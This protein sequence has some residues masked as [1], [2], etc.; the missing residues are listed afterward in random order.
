MSAWTRQPINGD[1]TYTNGDRNGSPYNRRHDLEA[2]SRDTSADERSRSRGPPGYGGF[3]RSAQD[4]HSP[5]R[6][7]RLDRSHAS[8][9]S[10]DDGRGWSSSRSRSRPA[11]AR[12]GDG[13]R[14][15]E[16]ILRYINQQW[17]FMS[18]DNCVPVKV[19]LQLMDSSSLGLA[20]Q[21]DQFRDT[22]Q[23][24]QDAL[25]N[26]VNEHHQGFNS[27]IGTFHQIQASIHASQARV[28]TLKQSLVQAKTN[29]RTTRPELK[30]FATS[31]QSYDQM[32][33]TLGFIEQLQVMPEK[34][35]ALIS[36]K[37]FL[38]AVDTL[39]DALRL[40]RKPEMEDIG[41]LTELRVYFHNQ[42]HSVTDILIEELHSHLYLK[43]PYCEERWKQYATRTGGLGAATFDME[44]RQL[45]RFLDSLDSSQPLVEDTSRNPEADTFTYIQL[46]VESL[47][48]MSCLDIAVNAIDQRL[49]VELFRVVEQSYTEVESR[50]PSAMRNATKKPNEKLDIFSDSD[51]DKKTILEDT[52]STLYA[53]FEAIAEGHRV[54]HESVSTLFRRQGGEDKALLRSFNELWKLYQ[55]EIR[56]LLHDHLATDGSLGE[57]TRKDNIA[58]AN[59]FRP[60]NRDRNKRLFKLSDTDS[61]S[62]ELS[63]EREDLDFIL[64]SSVPGLASTGA[65]QSITKVTESEKESDRSATGHKLLVEP[66]VFN[67][68]ILLP[69]SISFLTRLRDVVPPDEELSKRSLTSF[70]DDFLIN[71]FYPQLEYTLTDLC[72]AAAA[73]TD[74]WLEDPKWQA[75]AQV[76]I[77]KGTAQFFDLIEAFC[78]MLDSLPHDQT[79]S[80]LVISQMRDYYNKCYG[81]FKALVAKPQLH[82][83]EERRPKKSAALAEYN[84]DM[85]DLVTRLLSS[86]QED[87]DVDPLIQQETTTLISTA[88]SQ[89]LLDADLILDHKTL[90]SL[91]TLYTSIRWFSTRVSGLRHISQTA[92][93]PATSSSRNPTRRWTTSPRN[94]LQP[95]YLPLDHESARDFDNLHHSFTDLSALV[96]RTLHL[97]L[98]LQ[99]LA[100]VTRAL[101]TT[102]ILKQPYNDPDPA[103]LTLGSGLLVLDSNLS[104][105]LPPTQYTTV[106]ASL[107]H[108]ADRALVAF[109][110]K[111]DGMDAHGHARMQ[112]NILVLQQNLKDMDKEASLSQAGGYWELFEEGP[113]RIVESVKAGE[114]AKA[115][116]KS[117]VRLWGSARG[118]AARKEVD[119]TLKALDALP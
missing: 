18:S 84:A 39:Q 54:L 92:T 105:H 95:I 27:S 101:Q 37:R 100:G 103:I 99:I 34:L 1:R 40:M 113:T 31:S 116:G 50:Y 12:Y 114:T 21:Y 47:D 15:V 71:V 93:S 6:P 112:L 46:L 70:L 28:R 85:R 72:A 111:V 4:G 87:E 91:C 108:L 64:K 77:F 58:T 75:R 13:S 104:L 98:R 67:M 79:S 43:S 36:E 119:E 42:E 14:Q 86:T 61:K 118:D 81:W 7:A 20:D 96:S 51:Q 80:Q 11:A 90:S 3:G 69:P 63:T 65:L 35:E 74:A 33:Q 62:A 97:E 41:A 106:T 107:S 88:K 57:R 17:S 16:D 68:G 29:L 110:D 32:L 94:P 5:I 25:K 2:S 82:A 48:R 83:S 76:P 45:Y 44:R 117:M 23:Q 56:S 53:K 73:A 30:A 78:R 19:A 89:P 8:R 59:L 109:A 38:A 10:R 60:H 115:D 49:P 102:Y 24:L 22:Q 55:S 9:R 26:I 52:L 66:S